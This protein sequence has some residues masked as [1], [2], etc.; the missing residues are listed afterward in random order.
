MFIKKTFSSK[1]FS[2][3]PKETALAPSL[4]FLWLRDMS[5]AIIET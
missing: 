5:L 3:A 4:I 1:D 2:F